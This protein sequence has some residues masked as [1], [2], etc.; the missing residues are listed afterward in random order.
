MRAPLADFGDAAAVAAPA[1][2]RRHPQA[3]LAAEAAEAAG[4]QDEFW[5][6]HDKIFEHQDALHLDDLIGYAEEIGLDLDLFRQAMED[7]RGAS[8]VASDVESADLS[9]VSGTPTFFINDR[10]HYGKYD[11]ETLSA[12]VRT[13][14][15]Q[16]GI[17]KTSGRGPRAPRD[18]RTRRPAR[19]EGTAS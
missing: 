1:A 5:A 17:S 4:A 13:A 2:H 18:A 14:R 16:A 15:I 8:Q 10:R 7:R 6:M 3:Q 19:A 12:A 9:S 11:I